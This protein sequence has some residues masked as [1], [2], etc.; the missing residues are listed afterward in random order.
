M[1]LTGKS[2]KRKGWWDFSVCQ[3]QTE[4]LKSIFRFDAVHYSWLHTTFNHRLLKKNA[5]NPWYVNN[6]YTFD[7][8]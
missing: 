2:N 5:L 1:Q 6:V 8:G 3:S 7:K 4:K